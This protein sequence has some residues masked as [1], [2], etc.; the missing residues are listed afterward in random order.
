[1]TSIQ[2]PAETIS[3]FLEARWVAKGA[4][5]QLLAGTELAHSAEEC[6]LKELSVWTRFCGIVGYKSAQNRLSDTPS[7]TVFLLCGLRP[8]HG[9]SIIGKTLR[10]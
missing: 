9:N 2:P 6:K 8:D 3:R 4:T 1:M 10:V 5:H 7:D